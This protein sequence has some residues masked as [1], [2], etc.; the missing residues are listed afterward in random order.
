MACCALDSLLLYWDD[1]LLMMGPFE[2]S[3]SYSYDEPVILSLS[4]T[5]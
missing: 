3:V 1:V 5:E 4:V 2:D